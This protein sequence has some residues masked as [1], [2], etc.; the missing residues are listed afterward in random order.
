MACI[1]DEKQTDRTE[2]QKTENKKITLRLLLFFVV[3][4]I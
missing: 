1:I 2:K 4:K 3:Y